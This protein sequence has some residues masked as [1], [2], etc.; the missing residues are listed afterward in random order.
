MWRS[1]PG[2]ASSSA[3]E[4]SLRGSGAGPSWK[5]RSSDCHK[6]S[7]VSGSFNFFHV[8][9]CFPGIKGPKF[10][11]HDVISDPFCECS[12]NLNG[13]VSD[14]IG[15][16]ISMGFRRDEDFEAELRLFAG[17]TWVGHKEWRIPC[18]N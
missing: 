11:K 1:W 9:E 8:S 3:G 4:R 17:Q 16:L 5:R 12:V 18:R 6:M 14:H 10:Q 7:Q 15:K 2:R 13:S